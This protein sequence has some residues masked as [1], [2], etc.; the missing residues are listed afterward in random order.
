MVLRSVAELLPVPFDDLTLEHVPDLLVRAGE[1]RET[2]FFERKAS[3]SNESLAKA[4][5]AF[6]N[7]L[8]G[9]LV[10]GVVDDG[11]G[12]TGIER[13]APEA[14]LWVKDMLRG[15]VLP[16]PPFRARWLPVA[17]AEGP[18]ILLVLVAESS[19]TPH[20]LTRRGAI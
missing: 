14:Q 8:G 10:V 2:I 12:L 5:A 16:I 9:L 20:L 7:T 13:R 6:A 18:G 15:H 11:D 4:C 1:E 3:V 17:E 19:T